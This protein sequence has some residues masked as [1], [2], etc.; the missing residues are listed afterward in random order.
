MTSKERLKSFEDIAK[1]MQQ[2]PAQPEDK[3]AADSAPSNANR[4]SP[5]P[6]KISR[7]RPCKFQPRN[8]FSVAEIAELAD[9]IQ[10]D[11]QQNAITVIRVPDEPG[12]FEIVDGERRWRALNLIKERTGVEPTIDAIVIVVKDVKEH[13]RRSVIANLHR[14]NLTP[15][16]EAAALS[17]LKDAGETIE[18]LAKMVGKSISYVGNYLVLH[19][20]P[21]SVKELMSPAL[22][23]EERLQVS[24]AV[25]IAR[26][27]KDDKLRLALAKEAVEQSLSM[28]DIRHMIDMRV[29]QGFQGNRARFTRNPSDDYKLVT[30]FFGR[31]LASFSRF[32]NM[33]IDA[34]YRS[35]EDET[36]DRDN[37]EARLNKIIQE[38]TILRDKIRNKR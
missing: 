8:F 19:T 16:E 15:T 23:K 26:S 11:G 28:N 21:D 36:G 9:S 22:S 27:T 10:Q 29:T 37:D 18:A 3:V 33:D 38:A 35:R 25:E 32:H 30:S 5:L 4:G 7:V 12:A 2:K 34:L 13:F 20:L 6:I 31:V 24:A 14:K 1:H 17:N